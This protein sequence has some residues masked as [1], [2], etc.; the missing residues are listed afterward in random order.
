VEDGHKIR[1][2]VESV[3]GMVKEMFDNMEKR[4]QQSAEVITELE[5]M[6]NRT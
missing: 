3:S 6:K 1:R 4:R 2:T 5:S